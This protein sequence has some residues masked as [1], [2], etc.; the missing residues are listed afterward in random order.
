MEACDSAHI[1]CDPYR[2]PSIV[3]VVKSIGCARHIIW[4]ED[5]KNAVL[6]E[7]PFGLAK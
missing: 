7:K 2:L 3:T 1:V 5:T 4:L 6:V